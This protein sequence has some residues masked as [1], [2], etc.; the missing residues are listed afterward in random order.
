[1][2]QL[3]LIVVLCAAS[4]A[5]A[6]QSRRDQTPPESRTWPTLSVANLIDEHVFRQLHELHIVPSA[7]SSDPE[8]LRRLTLT[9]I[10]QLPTA[11]EVRVFVA[12]KQPDKR[13]RKI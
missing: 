8:F 13:S 3:S 5:S 11:A 6:D 10:G 1:M 4:I 7:L 2:R 9:T 12:D